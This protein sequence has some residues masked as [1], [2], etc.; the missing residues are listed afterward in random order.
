MRS[1]VAL[2]ESEQDKYDSNLA[3]IGGSVNLHGDFFGTMTVGQV[4]KAVKF[5]SSRTD[6]E[7]NGLT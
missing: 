2:A 5:K 7:L 3:D 6:L 1:L 4:A